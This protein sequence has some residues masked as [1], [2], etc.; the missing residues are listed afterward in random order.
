[1]DSEALVLAAGA[2]PFL[3]DAVFGSDMKRNTLHV[4]KALQSVHRKVLLSC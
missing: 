1:M 2:C 3:S 4:S